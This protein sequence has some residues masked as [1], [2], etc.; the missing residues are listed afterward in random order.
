MSPKC[1]LNNIKRNFISGKI[2][3]TFIRDFIHIG[4]SENPR[5]QSNLHARVFS[6]D[7]FLK[8]ENI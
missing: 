6:Q 2:S 8:V 4:I 1:L 5:E 7:I 3:K